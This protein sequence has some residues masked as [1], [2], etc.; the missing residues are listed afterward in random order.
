MDIGG[1]YAVSLGGIIGISISVCIIIYVTGLFHRYGKFWFLKYVFYR[2]IPFN[3]GTQKSLWVAILLL[4]IV[5]CSNAACLAVGVEGITEFVK[6]SG[7]I[8]AINLIPLSLGSRMNIIADLCGVGLDVYSRLHRWLGRLTI[9][10][11]ITHVGAALTHY[12]PNL[13][14]KED[15]SG[16]IVS[17]LTHQKSN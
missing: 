12:K 1:W 13:H 2:Q 14:A 15:V 17:S 7:L 4:T 3:K 5:F 10:L 8:T 9:A 6:R 11:G 16:I